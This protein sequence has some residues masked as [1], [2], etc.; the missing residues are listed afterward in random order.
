M[1]SK[2]INFLNRK[3]DVIAVFVTAAT[4]IL[5]CASCYWVLGTYAGKQI[6]IAQ[7]TEQEL[8]SMQQLIERLDAGESIENYQLSDQLKANQKALRSRGYDWLI[9]EQALSS[10]MTLLFVLIII[11][12]FFV[13]LNVKKLK[14]S[15]NDHDNR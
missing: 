5:F 12:L 3:I 1:S 13:H 2:F 7:Q 14:S 8:L 10:L 9:L 6:E 4:L 11:H 15:D